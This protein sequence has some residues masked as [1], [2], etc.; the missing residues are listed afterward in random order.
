MAEQSFRRVGLRHWKV[1]VAFFGE[2]EELCYTSAFWVDQEFRV[3]VLFELPVNDIRSDASMNVTLARPDL[4][5]PLGL[6]H[7][8]GSE[9]HVWQEENLSISRNTIQPP[10][11]VS[12]RTSRSPL[13]PHPGWRVNI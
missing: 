9:K 1:E 7:N 2:V 5:L 8:V 3:P 6:L 13:R 10:D 11:S 4:H 12:R